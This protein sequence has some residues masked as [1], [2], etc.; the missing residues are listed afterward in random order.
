MDEKD[1]ERLMT[2]RT[3][4]LIVR[5]WGLDQN[6]RYFELIYDGPF[7]NSRISIKFRY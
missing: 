6:N 3:Q 7:F 5:G 4:P 2:E 1:V